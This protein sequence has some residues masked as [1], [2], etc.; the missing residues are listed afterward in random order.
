MPG[1]KYSEWS[2][3]S[4]KR[5]NPNTPSPSYPSFQSA[6]QGNSLSSG[7]GYNGSGNM[8]ASS[9]NSYG[10]GTGTKSGNGQNPKLTQ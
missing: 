5:D 3:E 9:N 6:W 7:S 1:D 4:L 8:S 10:Y 2:A